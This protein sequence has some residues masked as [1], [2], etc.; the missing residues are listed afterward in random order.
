MNLSHAKDATLYFIEMY[1]LTTLFYS[2]AV[3]STF[4][5]DYSESLYAFDIKKQ[6]TEYIILQITFRLTMSIFSVAY[7]IFFMQTNFNTFFKENTIQSASIVY[8]V[9]CIIYD[10][11]LNEKVNELKRRLFV[12]LNKL[13]TKK[14]I[15]RAL[16]SETS[17]TN[18]IPKPTNF[19]LY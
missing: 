6:S 4:L 12:S 18:S 3:L 5:L 11:N 17:N 8:I 1:I 15:S 10:T 2:F 9:T 7:I 14:N 19:L 13:P 16:F